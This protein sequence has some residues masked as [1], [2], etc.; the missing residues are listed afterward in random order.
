MKNQKN[1]KVSTGNSKFVTLKMKFIIVWAAILAVGAAVSSFSA[2]DDLVGV[3]DSVVTGLAHNVF[4][5]TTAVVAGFNTKVVIMSESLLLPIDVTGAVALSLASSL[6][7]AVSGTKAVTLDLLLNGTITSAQTIFNTSGLAITVD[8][9]LLGAP[10]TLFD[11]LQT[12][13]VNLMTEGEWFDIL[14]LDSKSN[15]YVFGKRPNN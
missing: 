15:S 13:V 5:T 14:L 9:P 10:T 12:D 7:D 11:F 3:L 4:G 2:P 8:G 6:A 1:F